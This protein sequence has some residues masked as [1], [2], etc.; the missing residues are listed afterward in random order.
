M[1][2]PCYVSL[3]TFFGDVT[4]MMSRLIF[5][6]FDFVIT[7][8][9]KHEHLQVIKIEDKGTGWRR[10]PRHQRLAIFENLLLK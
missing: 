7:R 4:E 8:L 1:E 3:V 6:K 10:D 5:L 9:K 2:K